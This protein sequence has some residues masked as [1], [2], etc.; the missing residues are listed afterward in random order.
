MTRLDFEKLLGDDGADPGCDAA[1][2]FMDAYCDAVANGG[3]IPPRFD[4]FLRHMR[5]CD[6]CRE[7]TEGLLAALRQQEDSDAG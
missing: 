3:S 5:N 7:D 2:E 4:D 1:G 6:A